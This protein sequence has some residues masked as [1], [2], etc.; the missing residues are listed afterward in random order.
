MVY[1]K[2]S[3]IRTLNFWFGYV[4]SAI[5]VSIFYVIWMYFQFLPVFHKADISPLG[6]SIF[7]YFTSGFFVSL[8][9][10]I[11]PWFFATKLSKF[12]VQFHFFY[13]AL[14]GAFSF[15]LVNCFCAVSP[16][17]L[18]ETHRELEFAVAKNDGLC[19]LLAGLFFGTS[20]W[21]L[22]ERSLRVPDQ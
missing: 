8:F 15:F 5:V 9:V 7:F 22:T 19:F 17:D 6:F 10:M 13:F 1:T 4:C 20:Y 16:Y 14:F 2:N 11:I 3:N 18:G 12:F 21:F